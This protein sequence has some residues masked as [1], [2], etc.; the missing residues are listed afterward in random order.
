[1]RQ[2]HK[3]WQPKWR[4]IHKCWHNCKINRVMVSSDA[5]QPI[6]WLAS[7]HHHLNHQHGLIHCCPHACIHNLRGTQQ[8]WAAVHSRCSFCRIAL[9]DALLP[10]P[11][12]VERYL[13]SG[14]EG[15]SRQQ[16]FTNSST[17]NT[18]WTHEQIQ[19]FGQ[20]IW[21]HVFWHPR[22]MHLQTSR[23]EWIEA[24]GWEE[25]GSLPEG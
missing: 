13:L 25:G 11:W 16:P 20:S 24:G 22:S 19:K 10:E 9:N 17:S 1:M 2:S 23:M 12:C 7:L 5:T 21:E 6:A 4:C 8:A 3:V 18:T 14:R 15:S